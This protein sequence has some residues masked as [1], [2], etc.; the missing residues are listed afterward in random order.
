MEGDWAYGVVRVIGG[1]GVNDID[2][3]RRCDPDGARACPGREFGGDIRA[4][5]TPLG[6]GYVALR[7][8]PG[9]VAPGPGPGDDGISK[10]VR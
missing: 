10:F 9:N 5:F 8:E 6:V 2:G 7:G 1:D 4:P 3:A